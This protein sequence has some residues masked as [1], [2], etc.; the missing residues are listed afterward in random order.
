M[1]LFV[2]N[3]LFYVEGNWYILLRATGTYF[4]ERNY[5]LVHF[6]NIKDSPK[7]NWSTLLRST[8]F[9]FPITADVRQSLQSEILLT[10]KN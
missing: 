3:A 5:Q 2:K 10:L 7:G 4:F 1:F 8:D 9:H 6:F